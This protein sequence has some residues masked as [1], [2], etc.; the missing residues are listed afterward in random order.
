MPSPT[1][2]FRVIRPHHGSRHGGFEE[3]V[4]QL[5]ALDTAPGNAFHRKGVGA[6]AG[7]ECYRKKADGSEIGWQAKYFFELGSGEAAQLT[8]SFTQAITKHPKLE[9]FVVALPFNLSD[10]RIA[11]RISQRERWERWCAARARAIT[12]RSV[13]IELWDETAL[14]ERLSRDD[15]RHAGRR[16]YWFDAL[17]FTPDWFRG[18]FAITR[19]ALGQRYTPELNIELPVRRGLLA[20]ARDPEFTDDLRRLA[21][22]IDETRRAATADIAALLIG[23]PAAAPANAL[24]DDFR[25][26][27]ASIR[28]T[29]MGPADP[30]PFESWKKAIEQARAALGTC[31]AAIWDLRLQQGGDREAIKRGHYYA[32]KLYEILEA[33]A[34]TIDQPAARLANQTRLLL[35]GEAGSGKSHLLADTADNHIAQGFPAVL[36]L[37]GSFFEAEPWR[38]VADQLGLVNA[39][40]D[41]I[42]GALDAAGEAAGSRALIMVDAINERGGITLW[43][44]RLPAFL[45][46]ADRFPHVAIILSCRTTF[47]PY[48]VREIDE[49]ALPRLAHPGFAG[50]AAEA[51][52]RYLD[53]RG[54]VRMAA[55][56]FSPEFENPLFLRTCC[57]ALLRRGETELPRG[58]AGVSS[59]FDFYFGAVSESITARMGLFP[60][61]RIVETAIGKLTRAMVEARSG[62]LPVGEAHAILE[63]LHASHNRA[64][65]SLF[66]HL[67]TEGVIT[68]EP[69][70]NGSDVD[71]LFRFTFER[72]SDHVIAQA[73]LDDAIAGDDPAPAFSP[74]GPLRSYVSGSDSY[75][76]AGVA[77]AFA[78]QLP[79]RYG[80]ELLDLVDDEFATYDLM[81]GFR[82]SLLWRRQTAF[83]ARTI[84]ILECHGNDMGEDLWL[85]TLVAIATEPGNIFNAEHLDRWLRPLTLPERDEQWSVRAALLAI[86]DGNAID[87]LIQWVLAN[88]LR[89]IDSG[90][91]RLAAIALAWLTSLSHRSVRDMA[92]KALAVLLVER[93]ALGVELVEMFGCLNDPYI[94]DR[95]LAAA[96][97]AA[98]RS[99]DND[100]LAALAESAFAVVFAADPMPP[101]ALIRDHARGIVELAA[102]RGVLP[103]GVALDRARPPYPVG[104]PLEEIDDAL[105]ASYVDDYGGSS[106][107]DDIM[108]SAFDDGDFARYEIDPLAQ[109]FLALSRDE[110]SRPPEQIYDDWVARTIAGRPERE[111]ALQKLVALSGELAAIPYGFGLWNIDEETNAEDSEPT[112]EAVK[113]QRD[114]AAQALRELLDAQEWKDYEIHAAGWIAEAMWET[115]SFPNYPNFSAMSARRWVA[116][117]AHD[118]GWSPQRFSDFDRRFHSHDRRDH[119]IERIG[120]KYQWIAFHELTA[121]L[122]DIV[123]VD[124]SFRGGPQPYCGPWQV[125]TREMDPSILLTRTWERDTSRQPPTWWSP[126]DPR[127]REDPPQARIAW[128]QDETRDVPD[129]H[130]Q[131]DVTDPEGR[132]WL[133]LDMGATRNQ[134]VM[135]DGET[136]FLRM[137]WH[138]IRSLL[139]A[140]RNADRLIDLFE[141]RERERDHL[142]K[143]DLPWR[144]YLGEYP[145]HPSYQGIYG[146]HAMEVGGIEVFGTV[147]DRYVERSGHNYSIEASF[148]LTLPSPNLIRGLDLSLGEGRSLAF[149]DADGTV[150][151]KDPSSEEAGHSAA[152]VDRDILST[153]L[154]RE[155][156]EL[157]WILTGEKSVHGR[158]RYRSVWGGNLEYW[159]IYRFDG[160]D[161][162][163]ELRFARKTPSSDKLAEFLAS[164]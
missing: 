150:R 142:P 92:T 55:P 49:A 155:G 64:E 21:D 96:Y 25:A 162:I 143:V 41:D 86:E 102:L 127:W 5:A 27:I 15:P 131:L 18:R 33:A 3:L 124:G 79:E 108:S 16:R 44:N 62:Y 78:V 59:V 106:F 139:V 118:M 159:G 89:P 47:L 77:E 101:H 66:F 61:L 100:G 111:A 56:S 52:Q 75:R 90:R 114:A 121:R 45:A 94:V 57:D 83:S 70:F 36:V 67:E 53:Q 137:S 146:E 22:D 136:H 43:A 138:K 107:R 84:E 152:V 140:R 23:G 126:H 51:T 7:L 141:R 104:A 74:D 17:Q 149:G 112:R 151:F 82:T 28:G 10:G 2:D 48:I 134:S 37:G 120:K 98:T 97:A 20:I 9:R 132:R 125:D 153:F 85:D 148:N 87:T 54:I 29:P 80:V 158:H 71:E 40:P 12:P 130:A 161:I 26:L 6:D 8:E 128:M 1:I 65:N 123:A 93:R 105:L 31:A 160:S 19:Q 32:D 156:L 50:R 91:A 14:V 103:A 4:C 129:P 76:F 157:V 99:H 88:G 13:E 115:D 109:R 34:R 144:A 117:R 135:H 24:D 39:A 113:A 164:R 60:R 154:E 68:V 122:S 163:G 81:P 147:A 63:S 145:W 35:T 58:L 110:A 69:V 119:R 72:L 116:W 95:V 11:G 38:Q 42:L 46:S 30:L 73:L 133:V